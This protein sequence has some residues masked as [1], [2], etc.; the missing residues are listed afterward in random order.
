MWPVTS[1]GL[2]CTTGY[3]GLP[4]KWK[5]RAESCVT[6]KSLGI[7]MQLQANFIVSMYCVFLSIFFLSGLETNVCLKCFSFNIYEYL[8]YVFLFKI[9][10]SKTTQ[11]LFL[12][13]T[14]L[15]LGLGHCQSWPKP[16]IASSTVLQ[17]RVGWV[18]LWVANGCKI[19]QGHARTCKDKVTTARQLVQ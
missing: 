5:L 19:A 7:L 12:K 14:V 1:F 2:P 6:H 17:R 18:G 3:A 13:F 16:N 9:G 4:H 8:S 15:Q 10:I 11:G